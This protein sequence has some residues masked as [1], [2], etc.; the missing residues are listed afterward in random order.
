M[1][2]CNNENR[3]K[4]TEAIKDEARNLGVD[5]VTHDLDRFNV[6][7]TDRYKSLDNLIKAIRD[8]MRLWFSGDNLNKKEMC[9]TIH[10]G[11]WAGESVCIQ[12][13]RKR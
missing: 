10:T 3:E 1:V 12:T 11:I 4:F 5:L 2:Y 8:D 6:Y 13:R 9:V 7:Y